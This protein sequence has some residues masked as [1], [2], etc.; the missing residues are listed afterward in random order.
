[1]PGERARRRERFCFGGGSAVDDVLHYVVHN[2][3][4]IGAQNRFLFG[5][6]FDD[7][8]AFAVRDAI[9]RNGR[10][11]FAE[12]CKNSVAGRHL[13]RRRFRRS[14]RHRWIRFFDFRQTGF[15]RQIHHSSDV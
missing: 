4:N 7:R 9:D 6:R 14:E 5:F 2:V 13:Q 15:V 3:C 12:I 11:F 1:M 10:N 8:R